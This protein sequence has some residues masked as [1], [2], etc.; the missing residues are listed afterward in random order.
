MIIAGKR[1]KIGF[2]LFKNLDKFD[3]VIGGHNPICENSHAFEN[4]L[5]SESLRY[6]VVTKAHSFLCNYDENLNTF[7]IC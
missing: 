2:I 6:S 1:Y 7:I 3:F 5:I 4:D